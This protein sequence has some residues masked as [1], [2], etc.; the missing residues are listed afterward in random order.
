MRDDP[1]LSFRQLPPDP[2]LLER[3]LAGECS[4]AEAIRVQAWAG[5]SKDGESYVNDVREAYR[6]IGTRPVDVER[7]LGKVIEKTGLNPGLSKEIERSVMAKWQTKLLFEHPEDTPQ[8]MRSVS[9]TLPSTRRFGR[10]L[11]KHTLRYG[12]FAVVGG[13]ATLLVVVQ[14]PQQH[15]SHSDTY[16][17]RAN[18]RATIV[19]RDGSHARLAPSTRLTVTTDPTRAGIDIRV[20][21]EA[22]FTVAHHGQTPFMVHA[23]T[24]VARVLGT[25]FLVRHYPSDRDTHVVVMDGRVAVHVTSVRTETIVRP[26]VVLDARMRAVVADSGSVR[27]TPNVDIEPYMASMNGQLIFRNTP[28]HEIVAELGHTYG[29]QLHVP[30]SALAN[31]TLNWTV[32]VTERSLDDVLLT[33][34]DVLGA[35]YARS[36]TS[37]T[38]I[39]GR[40]GAPRSKSMHSFQ[41]TETQYGR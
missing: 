3:Y 18:Q 39:A 19:L 30:D 22:L 24:N 15:Q 27:I 1:I 25:T 2:E 36:G 20:H 14:G 5:A 26:D 29:V 33:L 9:D 32:P 4:D 6:N 17:T 8:Q 21:G 10:G 38:I 11:V 37:I 23:G 28:I 13:I 40:H 16:R 35:H 41:T 34:S 31:R 12:V 7:V